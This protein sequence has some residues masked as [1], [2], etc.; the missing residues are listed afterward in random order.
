MRLQYTAVHRKLVWGEVVFIFSRV[1]HIFPKCSLKEE[2]HEKKLYAR[3][4]S[5]TY[6]SE[7]KLREVMS[8]GTAPDFHGR[9][10]QYF[11]DTKPRDNT[12]I[13]ELPI[14]FGI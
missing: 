14:I 9:E 8:E 7:A 12:T 3:E 10:T 1:Y 6:F 13:R 5:E 4:L 2:W 11:P